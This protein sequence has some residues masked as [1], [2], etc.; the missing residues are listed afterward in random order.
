MNEMDHY[1]VED[2]TNCHSE[3]HAQVIDYME[4]VHE[5]DDLDMDE[6]IEAYRQAERLFKEG[7]MD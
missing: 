4:Q 7:E 6:Y 5:Y 3:W 2:K 1:N